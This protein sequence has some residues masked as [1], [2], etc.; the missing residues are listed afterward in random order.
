MTTRWWSTA[1]FLGAGLG[2]AF[3][4]N[5][6]FKVVALGVNG[7]VEEGNLTSYLIRSDSQT[8]YLALDAGSVLPGISKALAKGSFPEVTAQNS[9]PFT[10]QGAVFRQ[11]ISAYFISHGH[12][13]HLAGLIVAS[14]Q[15]SKKPIYG[16]NDT[17]DILRQHYFNWRVWPNF[18]D[19]GSGQ[20]IGTYRLTAL[21][22]GQRASL[23]TSGLSGVVYPLSHGGV[24]SSMLLVSNELA[25]QQQETFAFFGDTGADKQEKSRDLGAIWRV[26]GEEIKQHRLKGMI[27]ETSFPNGVP[28]AQL[29]GHLTPALLLGEL[30]NLEQAAG[31]AGSLK[32]LK[33]VISHIK[34]SLMA[35]ADP[36]AEIMRQLEEG[37]RLGVHFIFM[38][39]GDSQAF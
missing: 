13:D 7:G 38:Q 30:K 37:N 36:R 3:S 18:S 28:D 19:S 14:P 25:S 23:G 2:Y 8:R 39:Q 35:G 15:D 16:T 21:R 27:I 10:P 17:I 11:L 29:F 22:P 26:L 32:G 5:A 20:R 1:L 31:G 12:L 24:S 33:I 6:G 9:A 4:A 34:P